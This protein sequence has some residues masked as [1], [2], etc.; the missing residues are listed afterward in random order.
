MPTES[1]TKSSRRLFVLALG[2]LG[3]AVA[4]CSGSDD[5][6]PA[7]GDDP[8]PQQTSVL[9][10]EAD[11]EAPTPTSDPVEEAAVTEPAE[12]VALLESPAWILVRIWD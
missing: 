1:H 7:G 2:A 11:Q 5:A 3:L 8:T 10:A 12:P 9:V 4:A 6:F